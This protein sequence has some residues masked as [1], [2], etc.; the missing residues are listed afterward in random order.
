LCAKLN[1]EVK[2]KSKEINDDAK[3]NKYVKELQ[4]KKPK[5]CRLLN[6]H[7]VIGY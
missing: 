5:Y 1:K 6:A 7:M 4:E 3:W 2:L